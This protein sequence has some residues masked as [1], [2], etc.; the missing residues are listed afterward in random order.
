MGLF[1]LQVIS[2]TFER[3]DY[4][5]K[6]KET[7]LLNSHLLFRTIHLFFMDILFE[8][9]ASNSDSHCIRNENFNN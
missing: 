1:D 8:F 2:H 6:K 5:P 7:A 9:S 3:S 4:L